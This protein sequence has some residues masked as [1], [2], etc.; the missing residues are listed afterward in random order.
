ME[1][2]LLKQL[3]AKRLPA[4]D[5]KDPE[6]VARAVHEACVEF[7]TGT[8]HNPEIEIGFAEPGEQRHIDPQD[9]WTV[10]YEAGPY[11]WGVNLSFF[12]LE[13]G[14]RLCEPYYGFDLTFYRA[15]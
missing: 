11:D 8:G 9:G 3:V 7:A 13:Q 6:A 2:A 5:I 14:A 4:I 10:V 12:L 15:A 1:Y